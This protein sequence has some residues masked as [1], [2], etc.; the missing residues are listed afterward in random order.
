MGG[1]TSM[2][3]RSFIGNLAGALAG[4]AVLPPATTYERIWRATRPVSVVHYANIGGVYRL[5][6]AC[7]D[8]ALVEMQP[9]DLN[10]MAAVLADVRKLRPRVRRIGF[11]S[12]AALDDIAGK[13]EIIAS[14]Q[15]V[16]DGFWGGA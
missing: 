8:T 12:Q 14:K 4:F 11:C 15:T 16:K 7:S 10:A 9:L 6:N 3:R 1:Q 13:L 2:N 5:L